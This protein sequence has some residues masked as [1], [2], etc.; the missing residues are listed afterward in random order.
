MKKAMKMIL[1]PSRR[2][3]RIDVSAKKLDIHIITAKR[4]TIAQVRIH[5]EQAKELVKQ[6]VT[7]AD[8]DVHADDPQTSAR[9]E[10]VLY[11]RGILQKRPLVTLLANTFSKGHP[12]TTRARLHRCTIIKD[13]HPAFAT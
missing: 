7:V 4:E 1:G 2:L 9:R 3:H 13:N 11:Q 10:E 6:G 8:V 12:Q 5:E